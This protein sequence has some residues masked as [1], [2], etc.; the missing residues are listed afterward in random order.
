MPKLIRLRELMP[1]YYEDVVEMNTLLRVEQFQIDDFND[2][3]ERHA[4][5]QFVMTADREGIAVWEQLVGIDVR[6]SFDL[7]TRRYDVLARLL[8]P[9]PLTI[10][11]LRSVLDGL[12]IRAKIIV[13]QVKLHVTVSMM[14]TDQDASGRLQ[15]L[16]NGML[17]ANMTFTALNNDIETSTGTEYVGVA[18]HNAVQ[19]TNKGGTK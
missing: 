11:Y 17:P 19:I 10:K 3:V 16:L 18:S 5:N 15:K 7:E 4:A 6:P 9:K 1:S 13:D 12:N 8:P 2:M 14:T